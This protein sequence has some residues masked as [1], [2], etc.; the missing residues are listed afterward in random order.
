MNVHFTTRGI[1]L[2]AGPSAQMP[3]ATLLQ[4]ARVNLISGAAIWCRVS[5]QGD[6]RYVAQ[7]YL[8]L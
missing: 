1:S 4:G 5:W 3:L 2:R 8:R 6:S 7:A